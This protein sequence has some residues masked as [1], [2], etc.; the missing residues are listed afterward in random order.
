MKTIQGRLPLAGVLAACLCLLTAYGGT[1]RALDEGTPDPGAA[2]QEVAL[3]GGK[4]HFSVTFGNMD[5][6]G[7]TWVRLGNWTL[8]STTGSIGATFWQWNSNAQ[9][10]KHLL[11]A[12]TCTQ[13]GI[14][15][16]CN[17]YTPF[18][19]MRPAGGS[20]NWSG[21]FSYDAA[22]QRMTINWSNGQRE[23]WSVSTP[24]TGLAH[25]QLVSSSYGIT[26]GRG[27]GS[28]AAWATFKK[29]P[30]IERKKYSGARVTVR[31]NASGDI[32]VTPTAAGGWHPDE[33]DLTRYTSSANDN[34][35]HARL[36]A[37]PGTCT[38]GCTTSRTDIIYHLASPNEN[39]QMVYN[40]FCACLPTDAEF[41]CYDRNLHPYAMQQI[42][43]DSGNLRGF[44]GIEQQDEPG[45]DGYQYQLKE[46]KD[47]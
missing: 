32:S 30:E 43:D 14:S 41:P 18:G 20:F 15:K 22:A 27:Y 26:H 28:N 24:V 36:P 3:P 44:V 38:G 21:T 40:H 39:R 25:V 31:M 17:T 37:S 11:N 23:T 9:K 1:P 8:D 47:F 42:I 19:W 35:L 5:A 45:S 12:H 13:E 46:Y 29:V 2:R 6:S 16:S 10:G 7:E 4:Q 34:T 33:L